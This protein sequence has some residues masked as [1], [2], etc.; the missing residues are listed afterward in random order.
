MAGRDEPVH[1][2]DPVE[3][4]TERFLLRE[5]TEADATE[6][7]LGWLSDPDGSRYIV[8]SGQVGGLEDLRRYIRDRRGR[9]DVLFL[10]IFDRRDMAHIGNIKFEP[11]D[12]KRGYAVMGILIGQAEWRGRGVAGEVLAASARWLGEH[13]GVS[14]IL[15]GVDGEN[16]PAIRAYER[17]GFVAGVSPHLQAK[18][19]CVVMTWRP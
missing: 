9:P 3:I 6:R 19:G 7:Y 13:L 5:L 14:E 16:T 12:G 18:P 15:L 10:G 1:S 2:P 4:G 11:I 17:T 8:A